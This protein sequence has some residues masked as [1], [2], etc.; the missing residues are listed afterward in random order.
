MLLGTLFTPWSDLG[1]HYFVMARRISLSQGVS[2]ALT[3][4]VI[5]GEIVLALISVKSIVAVTALVILL[6]VSEPLVR[7]LLSDAFSPVVSLMWI[8]VL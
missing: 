3:V 7:I 4:S 1:T 2:I 5:G 6:A 8:S